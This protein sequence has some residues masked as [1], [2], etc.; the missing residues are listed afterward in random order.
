MEGE[1]ESTELRRH[2]DTFNQT[3]IERHKKVDFNI[4]KSV[5]SNR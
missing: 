3:I 1:N 2:P 4:W 5:L